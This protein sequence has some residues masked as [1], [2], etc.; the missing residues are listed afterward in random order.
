MRT[1]LLKIGETYCFLMVLRQRSR[2]IRKSDNN[3]LTTAHIGQT[4]KKI[5]WSYFSYK[6][7]RLAGTKT[8]YQT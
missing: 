2:F 7:H 8:E 5:F 6:I 3:K 1:G 4:L